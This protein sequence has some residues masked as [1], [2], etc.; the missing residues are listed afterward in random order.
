MFADLFAGC[1][2]LSLGLSLAGLSGV[3]AVEHDKMA[4]STLSANLIECRG[5]PVEQFAW[6]SWLEKKAWSIDEI[7]DQHSEELAELRGKVDVLAGGPPCQGFS[8]AGKRLESDPRNR[9][10]EKYVQM[11]NTIRPIALVLENVPGMKVAHAAKSWKQLGMRTNSQSYYDKLVESLDQIGYQVLGRIIDCAAFGVPQKRPR[12]IVIGI[13]KDIS[14]HIAGG[15]ARTF[16]LLEVARLQQLNDMGLSTVVSASEAI[17]DLEVG[18]GG[19]EPCT[20]AYSPRGFRDISYLGPRTTYQ[21]I[22]H[23]E[24]SGSMDSVRLANHKPEVKDRFKRIIQDPECGAGILMTLGQRQK[25]GLKKHRICLMKADSPAPTIT[26]LPDDI[27]HYS[28]PR[29]LTVRESARLQSFPDWF[30]FRGKFTTGGSQRV[31][32]CPRYTQVGNAVPPYLARAIG[33]A[34]DMMLRE[35]LRNAKMHKSIIKQEEILVMA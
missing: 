32:E 18:Y 19:T 16:E 20:D 14:H 3:F 6:P 7:F 28:E 13:R 5:V 22:M 15:V 11:V 31:K 34:V 8:F 35:A 23:A 26:T 17:S 4:F 9:L 2:G 21:N 24:C 27:L 29:I 12:L 25:Y 30:Q 33:K 1:G 10:F